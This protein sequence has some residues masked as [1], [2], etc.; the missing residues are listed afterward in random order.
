MAFFFSV[1]L[2]GF[3]NDNFTVRSV[4]VTFGIGHL[5]GVSIR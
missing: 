1:D 5:I 3:F 4:P 2:G